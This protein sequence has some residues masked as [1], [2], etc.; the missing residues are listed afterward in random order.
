M[1]M[2]YRKLSISIISIIWLFFAIIFL[3]LGVFHCKASKKKISHFKI[4]ERPV[5]GV[6]IKALGIGLDKPLEDFVK[7]F[8]VYIDEYNESSQTQN[9]YAA[10]V[11]FVAALTAF[12]SMY[13][14][15]SNRT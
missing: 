9:K 12:L 2:S 3:V 13:L 14:A 10:I 15:L 11:Y 5:A 1:E 6:N 4:T 7:N 8:N